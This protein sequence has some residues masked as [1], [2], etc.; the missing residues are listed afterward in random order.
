LVVVIHQTGF[1]RLG[2]FH[3]IVDSRI[4]FAKFSAM[5]FAGC[6]ID[7]LSIATVDREKQLK[8]KQAGFHRPVSFIEVNARCALI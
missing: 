4:W 8:M 6:S 2:S 3:L 1:G 5:A 7:H